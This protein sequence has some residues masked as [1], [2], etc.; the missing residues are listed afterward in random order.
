MTLS[1]RQQRTQRE[2]VTTM[3]NLLEKQ[4]FEAITVNQICEVALIHH[5]T[6]YRYFH[7][8]YALL[9]QLLATLCDEIEMQTTAET[10][11]T[12]AL[13]AILTKHATMFRN[14]TS[15][16]RSNGIY[17]DLIQLMADQLL[18]ASQNYATTKDPLLRQVQHADNPV[19]A[20]YGIAGMVVGVFVRWNQ[21]AEDPESFAAFFQKDAQS[22]MELNNKKR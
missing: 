18:V 13:I 9:S 4:P 14:L 10:A 20:S 12:Q 15:N 3:F 21:Q 8:K 11:F 22:L 6:F 17:Y 19:F 2:I 7:D 5:A 16:N 1:Q